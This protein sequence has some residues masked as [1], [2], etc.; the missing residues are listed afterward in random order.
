M[1]SICP[2]LAHPGL[3]CRY[4]AIGLWGWLPGT[5]YMR[6]V[7]GVR[8][9]TLTAAVPAAISRV[10]GRARC[11]PTPRACKRSHARGCSPKLITDYTHHGNRKPVLACVFPPR[12]VSPGGDFSEWISLTIHAIQYSDW[13]LPFTCWWWNS[14]LQHPKR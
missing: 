9:M 4:Q 8:P 13:N 2:A 1:S 7:L 5:P 3:F 10:R 11:R 6:P 14:A 12:N